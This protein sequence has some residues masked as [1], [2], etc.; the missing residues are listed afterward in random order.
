[1]LLGTKLP[2]PVKEAVVTPEQHQPHVAAVV[3][4]PVPSVATC[5]IKDVI[6]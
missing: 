1:M 2:P 3:P 5:K 4:T 6:I